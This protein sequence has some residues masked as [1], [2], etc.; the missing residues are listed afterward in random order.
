MLRKRLEK[1]HNIDSRWPNRFAPTPL[2][3]SSK[4]GGLQPLPELVS[5]AR[6]H[7]RPRS[8]RCL[9]RRVL[10]TRRPVPMQ[11]RHSIREAGLVATVPIFSAQDFMGR[12]SAPL[13]RGSRVCHSPRL[14]RSPHSP[15]LPLPLHLCCLLRERTPASIG[16]EQRASRS[17]LASSRSTRLSSIFCQI[18][19]GSRC[20]K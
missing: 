19:S 3:T 4:P 15:I 12:Q 1:A 8:R 7:H 6:R 9:T 14:R 17:C 13:P 2:S 11:F 18:Q 10:H 16:P 5:K 20:W